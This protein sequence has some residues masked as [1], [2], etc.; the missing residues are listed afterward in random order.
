M[1]KVA[2]PSGAGA[3]SNP[4][5]GQFKPASAFSSL[6]KQIDRE[7]RA[8]SLRTFGFILLC[9]FLGFALGMVGNTAFTELNKARIEA[10]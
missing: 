6:Q 2:S 10:E 5:H 4:T 8:H 7:L 9:T 3:K 1:S